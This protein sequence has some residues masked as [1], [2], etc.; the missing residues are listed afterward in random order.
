MVQ[1]C[2]MRKPEAEASELER[3]LDAALGI[4]AL[5]E[6]AE[7]QPATPE[8]RERLGRARNALGVHLIR[9]GWDEEFLRQQL[10]VSQRTDGPPDLGPFPGLPG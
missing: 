1:T 4:W 9:L 10:A 2:T 8:T 5:I 6:T 7:S 3:A